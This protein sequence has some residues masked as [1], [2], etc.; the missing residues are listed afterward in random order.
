MKSKLVLS[1]LFLA[2]AVLSVKSQEITVLDLY[3]NLDTSRISTGILYN[4]VIPYSSLINR[5]GENDT[6][7][8]VN[9]EW[10]QMYNELY[11]AYLTNSKAMI[12]VQGLKELIKASNNC[13]IIP[14][15]VINCK[16]N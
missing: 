2:N 11:N 5:T 6:S 1:M 7:I 8:I 10:L 3:K 16:F 4:T 14:I 9:G 13:G 12:P 15:G